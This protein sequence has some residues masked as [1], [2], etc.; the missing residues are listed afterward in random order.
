M[1]GCDDGGSCTQSAG[2]APG[3]S[4]RFP[5]C[6]A[7][8]GGEDGGTGRCSREQ[9]LARAWFGKVVDVLASVDAASG[10]CT[11]VSFQ[12]D[13]TFEAQARRSGPGFLVPVGYRAEAGAA[14][15]QTGCRTLAA[16]VVCAC[17]AQLV[18]PLLVDGTCAT[19]GKAV[20]ASFDDGML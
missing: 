17:F 5:S 18:P 16:S 10:V 8:I 15:R 4:R 13:R 11:A 9:A 1:A 3:R 6:F 14:E 2:A 20:A 12:G 19:D 7:G